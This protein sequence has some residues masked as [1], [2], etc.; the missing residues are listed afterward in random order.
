MTYT[1]DP[2]S[3]PF[4]AQAAD[5]VG[6]LITRYRR[7]SEG[8]GSHW[9]EVLVPSPPLE[10]HDIGDKRLTPT[11]RGWQRAMY[12]DSRIHQMTSRDKPGAHWSLKLEWQPVP[13]LPGQHRRVRARV[14]RDTEAARHARKA[15]DSKKFAT[16]PDLRN[17]AGDGGTL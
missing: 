1:R 12:Y 17:A 4:D 9:I 2:L 15:P 6:R 5:L 3:V 13:M 8:K 14:F 16:N 11:E 7:A 10:L